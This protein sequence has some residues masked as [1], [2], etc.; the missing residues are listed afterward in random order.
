M[1]F[2]S[3]WNENLPL[4][5]KMV[6]MTITF[7]NPGEEREGDCVSLLL[8]DIPPGEVHKKLGSKFYNIYKI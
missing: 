5:R 2:E 4:P 7:N 1:I 8:V 3:C 6:S